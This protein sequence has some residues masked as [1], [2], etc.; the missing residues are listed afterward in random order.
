MNAH[1]SNFSMNTIKTIAQTDPNRAM[2]LVMLQQQPK[3]RALAYRILKDRA[4]AEDLVQDVFIR[5][6]REPRL[7]N[8]DF[9]IS[10][11]LYRVCHNRALN[12]LRNGKR[13]QEILG[14]FPVVNNAPATQPLTLLRSQRK[15]AL[16][17]YL[18]ALS[19]KHRQILS[20]RYLSDLT[21][22]QIA[23]RLGLKIGTVMSRLSRAKVALAKIV[24]RE[25]FAELC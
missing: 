2:H 15:S 3:L 11:W 13:R 19:P 17:G 5:A 1:T 14:A 24:P 10:A 12:V 7:F 22:E 6:M 23:S 21:Y 18:L 8:P 9:A 20:A 4:A 25:R 16:S